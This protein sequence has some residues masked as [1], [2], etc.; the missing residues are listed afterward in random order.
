M[1]KIL[2]GIPYVYC[3]SIVIDDPIGECMFW[4]LGYFHVSG[5]ACIWILNTFIFID[6]LFK[7]I[8]GSF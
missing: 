7:L 8:L 1:P 6:M 5:S 2:I 4:L 3:E